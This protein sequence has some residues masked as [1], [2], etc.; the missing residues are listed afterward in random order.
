MGNHSNPQTRWLPE[1][2]RLAALGRFVC[3]TGQQ[4]WP[5]AVKAGNTWAAPRF[6]HIHKVCD[7]RKIHIFS[8]GLGHH[9]PCSIVIRCER[10][11]HGVHVDGT[12]SPYKLQ[13]HIAPGGKTS[14]GTSLILGKGMPLP[15]QGRACRSHR[16][17]R[18]G[19]RCPLP[20]VQRPLPYR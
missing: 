2:N 12:L 15:A 11:G 8:I 10:L 17:Q 20:H 19:A 14:A 18:R 6:H 13:G 5:G 1:K 9:L 4:P 3:V 7:K 16:Y